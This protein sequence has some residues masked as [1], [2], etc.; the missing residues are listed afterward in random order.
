MQALHKC[1]LWQ[2]PFV[3]GGSTKY[4]NTA[5]NLVSDKLILG[6]YLVYPGPDFKTLAHDAGKEGYSNMTLELYDRIVK[7]FNLFYVAR[8]QVDVA[9]N[10]DRS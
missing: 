6:V 8:V 4:Q 9:P 1:V 7:V 10:L 5:A 3:H 2:Y